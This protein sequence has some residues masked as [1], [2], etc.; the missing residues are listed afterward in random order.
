MIME[1]CGNCK[2]DRGFKRDI[3]FGGLIMVLVTMGFWV[4]AI[5]FYPKRCIVC[6]KEKKSMLQENVFSKK[7]SELQREADNSEMK[8][9]PYC[10]ETIKQAAIL[11]R[12]CKKELAT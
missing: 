12:F 2:T 3:G 1:Y 8:K 5:P 9:C 6:G 10:A 4:F 7:S 11:C